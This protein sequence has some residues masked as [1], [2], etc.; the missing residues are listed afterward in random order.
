MQYYDPTGFARTAKVW[1]EDGHRYP[2]PM[3]A[4]WKQRPIKWTGV[5]VEPTIVL[6][7][8]M[9]VIYCGPDA[10]YPAVP[11]PE[12]ILDSARWLHMLYHPNDDER[13][14]RIAIAEAEWDLG[15]YD[16]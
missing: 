5:A 11:T 10:P 6:D 2:F 16:V 13:A 7:V 9:V 14:G 12:Q 15:I 8:P 1:T 3:L 4:A